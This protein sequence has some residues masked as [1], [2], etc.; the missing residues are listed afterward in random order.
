MS[1]VAATLVEEAT[2]P[3]TVASLLRWCPPLLFD[4]TDAGNHPPPPCYVEYL[5]WC[6]CIE[7]GDVCRTPYD[8]LVQCLVRNNVVRR[9]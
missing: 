4:A 1:R 9:E 6:Q 5:D 2:M 7:R 8:R 3:P